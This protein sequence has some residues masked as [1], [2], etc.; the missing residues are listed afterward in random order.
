MKLSLLTIAVSLTLLVGC[1]AEKKVS[2]EQS[3]TT[4][5]STTTATATETETE[6]NVKDSQEKNNDSNFKERTIIKEVGAL[7]KEQAKKPKNMLESEKSTDRRKRAIGT[8][9]GEQAPP[10][11]FSVKEGIKERHK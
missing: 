2:T 11:K 10:T 3:T 5:E 6:T 4:P 9:P 7:T 1:S 8:I